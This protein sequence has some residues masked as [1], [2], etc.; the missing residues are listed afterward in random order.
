MKSYGF[1]LLIALLY[2]VVGVKAET[3]PV[4]SLSDGIAA[5]ICDEIDYKKNVPMIFIKD[6]NNWNLSGPSDFLVSKIKNG[7]KFVSSGP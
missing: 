2:S 7:F 6:K 4:T 3:P 1:P 5:F